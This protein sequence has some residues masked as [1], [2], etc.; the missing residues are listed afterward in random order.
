VHRL[1]RERRK[2]AKQIDI[3]CNDLIGAQRDFLRRLATLS[4]AAT[5]YRAVL[6]VQDI[7]LLYRITGRHIQELLP[8]VTIAF[9]RPDASPWRHGSEGGQVDSDGLRME[10]Y[11][12]NDVIRA[13]TQSNRT[14]HTEDMLVLGLQ[15]NPSL[16]TR[17]KAATVPIVDQGRPVG[18]ILLYRVHTPFP[19]A[20]LEP[21]QAMAGGLARA[22][23]V[24]TPLTATPNP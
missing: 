16:L 22:I 2:Q 7:D 9:C 15:V 20:E 4:H 12:D 5:Y 14:C 24:T 1:N 11:L 8:D 21:V 13:I 23:T 17:L 10:Q 6:G 18:F 3:L 19:A